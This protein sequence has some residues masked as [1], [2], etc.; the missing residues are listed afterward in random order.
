MEF[1]YFEVDPAS[2]PL[3][4]I[5]R[6][7]R[8]YVNFP[9]F[10]APVF[11]MDKAKTALTGT[12]AWA[13]GDS[14]I[15]AFDKPGPLPDRWGTKQDLEAIRERIA[16]FSR[17]F[18]AN[19]HI[20]AMGRVIM[21]QL[22]SLGLR[23]RASVIRFY[24]DNVDF[25]ESHGRYKAP[26][27]ICGHT[28]TGT[29]L[30]QRLM[31][32]DPNSRSPFTYELETPLPPLKQGDDPLADPRITKGSSVL[33]MLDTV[34][35]GL[36]A[37][38]GESHYLAPTEKEEAFTLLQLHNG[39]SILNCAQAGRAFA[40]AILDAETAPA[41]YAYERNY[42]TMLDAYA[43]AKSHWV[44]KAPPYAGLFGGIFDAHPDARVVVT[45]RHPSKN[46]A[47]VC[48]MIESWAIAFGVDG[49]WDKHAMAQA[50][51]ITSDRQLLEPLAF[52]EKNPDRE[53]QI[54]DCMYHD[55]VRDPI[56]MVR[57]IY[58]KFDLDLTP[59]FESRMATYLAQNR[60]GKHGRHK[61]SNAEYGLTPEKLYARYKPYYDHYG[62]APDAVKGD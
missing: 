20:S 31:S 28:R 26:L 62:Y 16:L 1:E 57:A 41:L 32:E 51:L 3:D 37:K 21:K 54:Y 2:K 25:I 9:W 8:N 14:L 53:A 56:A 39:L 50:T 13:L 29:T 48:R 19:P 23:N 45:H 17:G 34:A 11:W 35:P 52:R 18:D 12:H 27:L 4:G 55:L 15:R 42:M 6:Y 22:L 60:Q 59:E 36:V 40:E 7:P 33:K 49:S 10:V 38:F 47:S 44:N 46:I 61:Y 43:P 58:D 30:L 24:E 5:E